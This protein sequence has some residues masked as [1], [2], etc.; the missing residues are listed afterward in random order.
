[1]ADYIM[2]TRDGGIECDGENL[3]LLAGASE[4]LTSLISSSIISSGYLRLLEAA[5]RPRHWHQARRH[6]S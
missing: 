3:I 1:M 6:A 2:A 4:T 5:D